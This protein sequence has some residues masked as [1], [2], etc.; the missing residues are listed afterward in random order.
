MAQQGWRGQ[1]VRLTRG[2]VRL[3][4]GGRETG[5][6]ALLNSL[7]RPIGTA[8]AVVVANPA[9][10]AAKTTSTLLLAA[11]LG[12]VRGG[13]TVAWDNTEARGDL[14]RRVVPAGH[15]RA[16]VDLAQ[17]VDRL[18]SAGAGVGDMA[19]FVHRQEFFDALAA[20]GGQRLDT[21][22]P[23]TFGRVRAVLARFYRLMV[24]DTGNAVQ[25]PNW[26]SA[27]GGAH[28]L[29]VPTTVE[30]ESGETGLQTFD[31]LTQAGRRDLVRN[32]VVVVSCAD[33]RVDRGVLDQV[34]KFYR[35]QVR[36]LV[37]VPFD[38]HLRAG[39]PVRLD[40]LEERTR[41]AWLQVGA[42]VVDSLSGGEQVRSGVRI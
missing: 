30:V 14:A 13:Y 18:L 3:P 34:V 9:Y 26:W 6:A 31:Y 27:V 42:A 32:A 29:V 23:G 4:P 24:I 36:A 40:Q 17:E 35:P 38:E 5:D 39:R 41:R 15:G 33:R 37:V 7:R 20:T 11:T 2:A 1:V 12:R 21:I 16:V 19:A 25:V 28:C 22:D 10:G 8:Q